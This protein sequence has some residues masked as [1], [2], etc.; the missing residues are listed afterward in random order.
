MQKISADLNS[1][2][3]WAGANG[4]FFN[5]S[6]TQAIKVASGNWSSA[7]PELALNGVSIGYSDEVKDL[8]ILID[9]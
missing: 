5:V 3:F 4:L 7:I 8:R 2:S 6:K 1:I 9:N